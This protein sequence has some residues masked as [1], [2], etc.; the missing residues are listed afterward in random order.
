MVRRIGKRERTYLGIAPSD[1]KSP[2]KRAKRAKRGRQEVAAASSITGQPDD[3]EI[4]DENSQTAAETAAVNSLINQQENEA[5]VEVTPGRY[6]RVELFALVTK[7]QL[8]KKPNKQAAVRDI[9][10]A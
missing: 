4:A 7:V 8:Q 9:N 10:T 2:P 3:A 5:Q 1:G 6:K